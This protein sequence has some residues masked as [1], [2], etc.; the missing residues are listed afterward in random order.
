MRVTL[1]GS[2]LD[3]QHKLSSLEALAKYHK[4]E[5]CTVQT[6]ESSGSQLGLHIRFIWGAFKNAGDQALP[7]I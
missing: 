7:M 3:P 1:S 6:L 5:C 4:L 2:V